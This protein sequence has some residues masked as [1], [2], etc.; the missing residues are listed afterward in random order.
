MNRHPS[1]ES[2]GF[3]SR[4]DLLAS[5]LVPC[6]GQLEYTERCLARLLRHTGSQA[7][8]LFIDLGSLDGTREF[9]RGAATTATVA[10]A[11]TLCEDEAEFPG[12]IEETLA[13]A[14]GQ[15]IVWLS[16]ETMVTP[17]WIEGLTAAA[18]ATPGL[19]LISPLTNVP[20]TDD[21]ETP[22]FDVLGGRV[23][24]RYPEEAAQD[25]SGL[26]EFADQWRGQH[27]RRDCEPGDV[28]ES[29]FL[30]SRQ[31]INTLA[32]WG[33]W[34]HAARGKPRLAHLDMGELNA[35]AR[36]LDVKSGRCPGVYVYSFGS[37]LAFRAKATT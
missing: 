16:N 6:R 26:D 4:A 24:V 15:Y 22:P 13:A 19:E 21:D 27:G 12:V 29:C 7:E 18:R 10:L 11:V 28:T 37:R 32:P 5:I 31:L 3:N 20:A 36:R 2:P 33:R 9:L 14:R 1:C 17:G 35:A 34:T 25:L 30:A 23:A 8:F